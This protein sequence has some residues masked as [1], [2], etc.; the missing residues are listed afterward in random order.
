MYRP[1]KLDTLPADVTAEQ[2]FDELHGER[3][4]LAPVVDDDGRTAES[5]VVPVTL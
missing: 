2:A 5:S 4:S 1:T 3:R